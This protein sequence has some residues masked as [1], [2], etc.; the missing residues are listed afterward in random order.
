[1]L[2]IFPP[3]LILTIICYVSAGLTQLMSNAAVCSIMM[4][5]LL[6]MASKMNMNP[7][8][9]MLPTTLSCSFAFLLPVA[10]PPNTLAYATGHVS[11]RD[12]IKAGS[13]I[14]VL[15]IAIL[16]VFV[17]TY[18]TIFIPYDVIPAAFINTTATA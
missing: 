1:V 6:S 16:I 13:V 10:T 2:S 18:G 12:M 14:N 9:F 5:I 8:Y 4:P 3:E 15:A 11:T 17:I 7:L